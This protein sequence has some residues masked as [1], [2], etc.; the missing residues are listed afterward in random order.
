[1]VSAAGAV[2]VLLIVA[3][4]TAVAAL[5]T[6]F[7]RV[8]LATGW[9]TALYVALIVPV[10]ELIVTLVLS[11]VA[12]LGSDLGGQVAALAVVIFLPLALGVA[13][14]FFWMPAPEEVELPDTL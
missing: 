2:G 3:V 6:R 12:G 8:R 7:L 14:D 5:A 13:F 9:G 11:G 1:M 10:L 4:N